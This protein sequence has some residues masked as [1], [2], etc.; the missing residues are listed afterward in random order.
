MTV[1]DQLRSAGRAIADQVRDLPELDP[2][3]RT[4]AHRA[5]TR[6]SRLVGWVVPLTA[7]AAVIAVAAT[8]VAV[9]G[10]PGAAPGSRSTPAASGSTAS[11]SSAVPPYYVVLAPIDSKG[12]PVQ[13]AVL[14]ATSTGKRLAT[15]KPPSGT[16]FSYTAASADDKTFVLLASKF[17]E[18]EPPSWYVLRLPPGTPQQARLTRLPIAPFPD[19]MSALGFAVS[20]DGST[21]AVLFQVTSSIDGKPNYGLAVRTYSLTTGQVLRTW[22]EPGSVLYPSASP[23]AFSVSWL[24]DGSTLAFMYADGTV[25]EGVRFLNTTS[26][27]SNLLADSQPVFSPPNATHGTCN[28]LLP[29]PDGKAVICGTSPPNDGSCTKGQVDV[30]AYSLATGQLEEVLYRYRGSCSPSGSVQVMWA[31]SDTLALGA[32]FTGYASRNVVGL[33]TPGKFTP[34]PIPSNGG[35]YQPGSIAF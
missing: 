6:T 12:T 21:L 17:P 28:S 10:A 34:L 5:R 9:K 23:D 11:S 18:S 24:N 14:A 2:H 7:A 25:I 22:S 1:E 26:P 35:D 8:L 19:S 27:G 31:G 33:M 20:P 16:L 13:E 15:F 30:T 32:T 3:G 29:T 4:A